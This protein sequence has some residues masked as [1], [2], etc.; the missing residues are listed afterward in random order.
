[1]VPKTYII[2][3][4]NNAQCDFKSLG[5]IVSGITGTGE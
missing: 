1:M 3:I 4:K 2:S 5:Q